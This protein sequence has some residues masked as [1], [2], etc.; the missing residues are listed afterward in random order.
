M[1]WRILSHHGRLRERFPGAEGRSNSFWGWNWRALSSTAKQLFSHRRH[2]F[3]RIR[4]VAKLVG[5]SKERIQKEKYLGDWSQNDG[6]WDHFGS[7][8]N[9]WEN[10]TWTPFICLHFGF[11]TSIKID[12]QLL[13][14][15]DM[16]HGGFRVHIH[17]RHNHFWL[18]SI[19]GL[20]KKSGNNG[21]E[22][23]RRFWEIWS[24]E[25][26]KTHKA[27]PQPA[28]DIFS[29]WSTFPEEHRLPYYRQAGQPWVGSGC[30]EAIAGGSVPAEH[31]SIR[32]GLARDLWDGVSAQP[33]VQDRTGM[34]CKH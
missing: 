10:T 22:F 2:R 32:S 16:E 33:V 5:E 25:H 21:S 15:R 6:Y 3:W 23:S 7:C 29:G 24:L 14:R 13:I 31:R 19:F 9:R 12:F 20:Q 1:R 34:L 4:R 17:W 28:N 27:R 8:L 26:L 18:A 30:L 11:D